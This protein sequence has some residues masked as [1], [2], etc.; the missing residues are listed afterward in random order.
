MLEDLLASYEA[1]GGSKLE[2][3]EIKFWMVFGSFWWAVACLLMEKS[4]ENGEDKSIERPIIGRRVSE[5]EMDCVNHLIPGE[6]SFNPKKMV[7]RL[8]KQ[9]D[10][11][12]MTSIKTFVKEEILLKA[13]GRQK[14]LAT[15]ACNALDITI[16]EYKLSLIHI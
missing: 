8:E 6:A 15:I 16:R 5:C 3:E 14:F 2:Q 9:L 13:K 12:L 10:P 7:E 1:S 11:L 4:Y